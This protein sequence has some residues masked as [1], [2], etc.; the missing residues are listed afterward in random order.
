MLAAGGASLEA[1][2]ETWLQSSKLFDDNFPV[3][4]HL[5]S[6]WFVINKLLIGARNKEISFRRLLAEMPSDVLRGTSQRQSLSVCL[7]ALRKMEMVKIFENEKKEAESLDFAFPIRVKIK[8]TQKM[9]DAARH[10][11][12]TLLGAFYGRRFAEKY[13]NKLLEAMEAIFRVISETFLKD[14]PDGIRALA[15]LS[16]L[17]SSQAE[18]DED[19]PGL[20]KSMLISSE[21]FVLVHSLWLEKLRGH[22]AAGFS[23]E[24]IKRRI[25][26]I[27]VSQEKK[28]DECIEML[29]AHGILETVQTDHLRLGDRQAQALSDYGTKLITYR[30]RLRSDLE[31][32]LAPVASDA[33]APLV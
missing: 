5:A 29:V 32:L 12:L 31:K 4:R 30:S 21:Y 27:R 3:P 13:S 23:R 8:I 16:I 7:D 1:E 26:K 24:G 19:D 25:G 6:Q 20:V 18:V 14:W 33:A 22:D 28:W 2:I 9:T 17:K 15:D 10:Y 11:T